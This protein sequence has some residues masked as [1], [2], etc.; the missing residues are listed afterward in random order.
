MYKTADHTNYSL[1][2]VIAFSQKTSHF[3]YTTGKDQKKDLG[4]LILCNIIFTKMSELRPLLS[5]TQYIQNVI[6]C[7]VNYC[8]FLFLL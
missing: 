6:F 3:N 7:L 1:E 8:S 4:L 5:T 2:D